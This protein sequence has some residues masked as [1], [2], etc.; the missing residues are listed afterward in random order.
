[1]RK[2][3]SAM[4]QVQAIVY[5]YVQSITQQRVLPTL[6]PTPTKFNCTYCEFRQ[7]CIEKMNGDDW[8]SM[9]TTLF[10]QKKHYYDAQRGDTNA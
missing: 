3:S 7:V 9:L 2:D 1:M 8:E 5:K 4:Q 10:E 6:V